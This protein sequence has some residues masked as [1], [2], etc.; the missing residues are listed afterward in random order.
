MRRAETVNALTC[1]KE[2]FRLEPGVHFLNCA[3]LGPISR[4][5]EEAG[6]AGLARKRS[7]TDFPARAFYDDCDRLRERFAALIGGAARHVAILPSVSYGIATAARNLPLGKGRDVVLLGEQFPS[8][9]YVWRRRADEEDA[10]VRVVP[11]PGPPP[12]GARWN[13]RILHAIDADTAV[14]AL[15]PTHWTDGTR[16][17]VAA[18]GARAREVGAAFVLDG[19][20]SVG[21][22]PLDVGEVKPDALVCA[23]YKWL[24]GPYG[25]ALAHFGER[26]DHGVPL[27]ETWIA[28]EGSEDFRGLVDYEEGYA[29]GAVRFD[30]GERS[31]F[32]HVPMMIAALEQ[33][34]EWGPP[35]IRDYCVSLLSGVADAVR[36]RGWPV[37]DDAWR[38]GN[39]LGIGL[40]PDRD[41]GALQRRLEDARV[42]ASL[43]GSSLR[44]SPNVYN[45]AADIDALA[46]VVLGR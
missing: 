32:I 2:D 40:P 3:Y 36:E 18:I 46:E 28:R 43:R 8:N 9:V 5:T 26:F 21:A 6:I 38:G 13:E 27:E 7:P 30:V 23:G 19:S 41:P 14:V 42:Y 15:A 31:D 1:R 44:V 33:L 16:F 37:E 25:I 20:Q 34:L 11:R 17:D 24:L 29:E 39:I 12:C 10:R 35:R 45:D 4:R 22:V